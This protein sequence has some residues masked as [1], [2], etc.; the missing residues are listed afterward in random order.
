MIHTANSIFARQ[1]FFGGLSWWIA[2]TLNSFS[3]ISVPLFIML[4]GYLLLNKQEPFE[5]TL[6]RT[7]VRI[8]IPFF[9]WYLINALL[10]YGSKLSIIFVLKNLFTVN[11]FHLY[12]LVI[13]M[14]L[15]VV[16]PL[17][18]TFLH[19]ASQN[20]QRH[21]MYLTLSIGAVV[22]LL[23]YGLG[24]CSQ[25][26][27]FNYWFPY[28]GLFVAG[29]LLGNQEFKKSW[30]ILGIYLV[31]FL[32]TLGLG[33][34]NFY[35]LKHNIKLGCITG[36]SDH[37]LSVNV[38]MMTICAFI[39]LIHLKLDNINSKIRKL[40][41]SVARASFGIYLIHL[42]VIRILETKIHLIG[43]FSPLWLFIFINWFTVLLISYFLTKIIMRIPKL[44]L[45]LGEKSP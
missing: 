43:Y 21:L 26:N 28:T 39:F 4:S 25:G 13:M 24:Y 8:V 5:A 29:Y 31:G 22:T 12:F 37:Y 10:S 41:R 14:G 1:D 35:L 19:T 9:A 16:S 27:I 45:L 42:M 6:K 2:L 33:Y 36:Y 17:L 18:R 44:R 23:Q 38:Q 32:I 7:S 40:V 3:R 30:K 15:Y 34:F 20:S 11:V